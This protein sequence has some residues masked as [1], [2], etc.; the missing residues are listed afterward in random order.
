[1]TGR[2]FV[3]TTLLLG[4]SAVAL[5][6]CGGGADDVASPGEGTLVTPPPAPPP[7][8]PPAKVVKAQSARGNLQALFSADDYPQDALRNEETGTVTVNLSIGTNGRVTGCNVTGSSGSNSLDR[9]TCRIL[10]SRARFTPAKLSNGEPT[11]D[12]Y[13][14]R[15]T[16]RLQ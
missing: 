4:I 13:T 3:R 14:Q 15:I 6:G 1:M 11:T 5:A 16:W 10:Q 2:K 9:A 7:P 8:P 12:T